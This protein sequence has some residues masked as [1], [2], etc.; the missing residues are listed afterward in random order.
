MNV[1]R[2]MIYDVAMTTLSRM[3]GDD[4]D[5]S[6]WIDLINIEAQKMLPGPYVLYIKGR[7]DLG[8]PDLDWRIID[9]SPEAV[10][11]ELTHR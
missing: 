2:K 4:D 10:L 7:N 5:N 11:F 3:F 1:M 8:W 9:D 6:L